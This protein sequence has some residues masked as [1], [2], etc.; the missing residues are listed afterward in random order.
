MKLLLILM[1]PLLGSRALAQTPG[2]GIAAGA[3]SAA[4]A[5]SS[6]AE[7]DASVTPIAAEPTIIEP[8]EW[9]GH[10]ALRGLPVCPPGTAPPEPGEAYHCRPAWDGGSPY[11][12]VDFAL[13]AG[14]ATA[15]IPLAHSLGGLRA[16]LGVGL[17][18]N[19][20]LHASYSYLY[21]GDAGF[22][23]DN[24]LT[25]D[26]DTRNLTLHMPGIGVTGRFYTDETTRRAWTFSA[27]GGYALGPLAD[28]PFGRLSVSREIGLLVGTGDLRAELGG[29]FTMGF[30]ELEGFYALTADIGFGF[31]VNAREPHDLD[32]PAPDPSFDHMFTTEVRVGLPF[33][34]SDSPRLRQTFGFG[35]GLGIPL[36]KWL[37]ARSEVGMSWID[38]LDR[39]GPEDA[40]DGLFTFDGLAGLRVQPWGLISGYLEVLGGYAAPVGTEPLPIDHGPI[41]DVGIGMLAGGCGAGGRIGL[42]YRQ[43]LIDQ[44]S[45]YRHVVLSA[46]FEFN[47]FSRT[48]VYAGLQCG[49]FRT[50]R[51]DERR[52]IQPP[53]P[54]PPPP[55]RVTAETEL[56]VEVEVPRVEVEVEIE[57]LVIEVPIGVSLF[58]GA[59]RAQLDLTR[60]PLRQLRDAGFVS[61]EI[62]APAHET[63]RARAEVSAVLSRQGIQVDA[64]AEAAADTTQIRAIFTIWPAGH[65]P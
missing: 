7:A 62:V 53:P 33:S 42:R 55:P 46:A 13:L 47:S 27:S 36:T 9:R 23:G 16:E 48:G 32:E 18:R 64:M 3:E 4:T 45:E 41:L 31:G 25:D 1:V 52:I 5:T 39:D 40:V 49:G 35:F 26:E 50:P 22:D 2:S 28:G 43:G 6:P 59:F 15:E 34:L 29:S 12:L 11:V 51:R 20:S 38:G 14:W 10:Q 61:V 63:A 21:A 60:L 8:D 58:G 17:N 56:Q 54:P 37:V 19:L 57:P 65:R 24:S 30:G 44:N